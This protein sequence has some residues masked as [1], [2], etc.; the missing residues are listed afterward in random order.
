MKSRELHTTPVLIVS[1]YKIIPDNNGKFLHSFTPENTSRNYQFYANQE[2]IFKEG[3]RYNIG[4]KVI[5]GIN[6]VDQSASAKAD[7]VIPQV[8][9]Y[10]ARELGEQLRENETRKSIERVKHSATDGHYLGKKYAWRIYGMSIA[11]D[12]FDDYLNDIG[13]PMVLCYTDG[14]KSLAY[15]DC[16]IDTAMNTL[17][18]SCVKVGKTG[19]R[20]KSKLFPRKKWFTVKGIPAISDKK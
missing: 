9:H 8:S 3:E 19:N 13:H 2:P 15:K 1:N 10:V 20:F 16:G 18:Q 6:W 12:T 11:R 5:D 14:S 7:S 17:I 4:Y